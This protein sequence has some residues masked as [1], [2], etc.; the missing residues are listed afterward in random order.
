MKLAD[1]NKL[2]FAE[3]KAASRLHIVPPLF[4]KS[5]N[6]WVLPASRQIGAEDENGGIVVAAVDP[7]FY[8]RFYSQ[9]S[10]GEGDAISLWHAD[11]TLIARVPQDYGLVGEKVL[12]A[13][14][15]SGGPEGSAGT[16]IRS[17]P[18]NAD[19]QWVV[20]YRAVPGTPLVVTTSLSRT[21]AVETWR[22][23]VLLAGISFALL[24]TLATATPVLIFRRI[25]EQE[26][27]HHRTIELQKFE[28]LGRMT[29]GIA[30][31]F[32]NVEPCV[33]RQMCSSN[34]IERSPFLPTILLVTGI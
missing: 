11:A 23:I 26:E 6:H 17:D 16:F 18:F 12:W 21:A 10:L 7:S 25:R 3:Q 8:E 28:A 29:G 27:A 4:S 15:I 22:H 14:V 32:N 31:D 19:E 34:S 33:F 24:A 13:P 2:L 9:L 1:R 20:S 5:V 30:H